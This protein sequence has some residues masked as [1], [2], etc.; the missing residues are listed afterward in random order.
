[1]HLSLHWRS[2]LWSAETFCDISSILGDWGNTRPSNLL[3]GVWPLAA[4]AVTWRTGPWRPIYW[5][6]SGVRISKAHG[7][8]NLMARF[9]GCL[10]Q[11]PSYASYTSAVHFLS[12]FSRQ[13]SQN[14]RLSLTA[15][16]FLN[17]VSMFF[18][19]LSSYLLN[20]LLMHIFMLC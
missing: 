4:W 18:H 5:E 9:L 10:L 8:F 17:N 7:L 14:C 2:L 19:T 1:M 16:N 6:S 13:K 15:Y 3:C 20:K 11:P 12:P